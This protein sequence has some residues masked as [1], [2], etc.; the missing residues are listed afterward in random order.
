LLLIAGV[1]PIAIIVLLNNQRQQVP[2]MSLLMLLHVLLATPA[3]IWALWGTR[4][5]RTGVARHP[6]LNPPMTPS[7]QSAA[8]P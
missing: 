4:E 7:T 5:T 8:L 2:P 6:E 1:F 3:L